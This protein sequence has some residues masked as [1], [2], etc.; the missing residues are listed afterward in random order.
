MGKAQRAQSLSKTSKREKDIWQRRFCP[1]NT[2]RDAAYA[3]AGPLDLG[4]HS[5]APAESPLVPA[6]INPSSR[7]Y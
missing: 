4:S 5:E 7:V 2:P 6:E 3:L 1:P